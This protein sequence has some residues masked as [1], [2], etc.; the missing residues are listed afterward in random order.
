MSVLFTVYYC[1]LRVTHQ[2]AELSPSSL[3]MVKF[4]NFEKLK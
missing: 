1:D 4:L 3:E 2:E